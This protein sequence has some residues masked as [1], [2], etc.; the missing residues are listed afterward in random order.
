MDPVGASPASP[1]RSRPRT[2]GDVRHPPCV[3]SGRASVVGVSPRTLAR[4]RGRRRSRTRARPRPLDGGRLRRWSS[5]RTGGRS[6]W[7]PVRRVVRRWRFVRRG[8]GRPG[9]VTTPGRH[10]DAFGV[11]HFQELAE[12]VAFLADEVVG[13]SVVAEHQLAGVEGVPARFVTTG[14]G[15]ARA[16]SASRSSARRLPDPASA[17]SGSLREHRARQHDVDHRAA[18][19]AEH[20]V[21]PPHVQ[22]DGDGQCGQWRHRS[23]VG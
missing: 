1:A 10:R 4:P 18:D 22:A 20:R 23:R 8:R 13:D 14:V 12:F 17:A 7:W 5:P 3:V 15:R 19:D 6:P 9:P 11:E 21:A 2:R 16:A